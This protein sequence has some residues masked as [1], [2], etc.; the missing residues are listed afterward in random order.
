[1]VLDYTSTYI[2]KNLSIAE[3]YYFIADL[4][5]NVNAHDWHK[6]DHVEENLQSSDLSAS[7]FFSRLHVW[8]LWH[9]QFCEDKSNSLILH[10]NEK[11]Q[12]FAEWHIFKAV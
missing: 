9:V 5:W 6:I 7:G 3:E 4:M 1:M 12:S 11:N 10:G 2:E 8:C